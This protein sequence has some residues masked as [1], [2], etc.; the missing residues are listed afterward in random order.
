MKAMESVDSGWYQGLVHRANVGNKEDVSGLSDRNETKLVYM[1][2]NILLGIKGDLKD[3]FLQFQ[4]KMRDMVNTG[5][6]SRGTKIKFPRTGMDA[7]HFFTDGNHSILKNIPIQEVCEVYNYACVSLKE[8]ILR[9]ARHSSE[10]NFAWDGHL[11]MEGSSDGLNRT[12]AMFKILL[13]TLKLK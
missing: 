7:C 13:R 1:M 12:R 3:V 11:G 5:Q 10:F 4:C 9:A 2:Q 6:T 8:T